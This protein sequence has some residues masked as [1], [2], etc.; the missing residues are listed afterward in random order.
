MGK[1]IPLTAK[2]KNGQV[3]AVPTVV[4]VQEDRLKLTTTTVAKAGMTR[5]IH[6]M[7]NDSDTFVVYEKA[8]EIE[9]MRNPLTTDIVAKQKLEVAQ[10]AAANNTQASA[11]AITTYLNEFTTIAAGATDSAILDAATLGKTRVVVNNDTVVT[12]ILNLFPAVG[13]KFSDVAINGR[14]QVAP[15]GRIHLVCLVAGVWTVAKDLG[16]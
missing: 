8:S 7:D 9:A 12:D 15:R 6:F 4:Y 14:K 2:S 11:K 13:E 3:F 5:V 10:T 1:M 16:A